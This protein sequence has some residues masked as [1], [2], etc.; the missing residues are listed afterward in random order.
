MGR[1]ELDGGSD[2][3]SALIAERHEAAAR[4]NKQI[5]AVLWAILGANWL[6]A[7]GKLVVG[8]WSGSAA[9]AADGLH[10]FI[11][12]SNNII[13]LVAMHYASQP[14]DTDH[15]YGHQKFEALASL[16]I[17]A[18]IGIGLVELGKSALAAIVSNEHPAVGYDTLGIMVATLIVN[19]V[20]SRAERQ[21]AQ[22]LN[23]TLLLADAQHTMSDVF[24]SGS[25]IVSLV[26]S[27]LGVGRVDGLV[28]LGVLGA[29]AWAGWQIIR[30]A[31][32]IL[33]DAVQLDPDAVRSACAGIADVLAVRSVR[34]RGM[35]GAVYVDLK[36]DVSS[37]LSVERAHRA[38]DAVELAITRAFP[39]VVDVVVHVEPRA[40]P[41]AT[42]T[43][44]A[45]RAT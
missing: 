28:A 21:W 20:V 38:S 37:E 23:S 17:G 10:S 2:A 29:V 35:E 24:V 25:V 9:V 39:Q 18:M 12:G 7:A 14:A 26:L 41:A 31:V 45:D 8:W 43:A 13:G 1:I 16:A 19:L 44:A 33:S 5:K 40:A 22:R 15:P 3:A 32:G 11:D 34:S 30:Q 4:R 27:K 42:E 6:V 36:V